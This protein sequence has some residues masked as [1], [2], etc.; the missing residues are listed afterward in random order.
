MVSYTRA[1]AENTVLDCKVGFAER[2]ERMVLM[3]LGLF[4]H[5]LGAAMWMLAFLA[6]LTTLQRLVHTYRALEA[7]QHRPPAEP[8]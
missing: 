5:K 7:G 2:G 1:R 6:W 8:A 4:F 3:L